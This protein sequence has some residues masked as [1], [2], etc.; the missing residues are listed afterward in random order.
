[1]PLFDPGAGR[2]LREETAEV[3]KA[4]LIARGKKG[5]EVEQERLRQFERLGE[6][7]ARLKS[8]VEQIAAKLSSQHEPL[9][10]PIPAPSLDRNSTL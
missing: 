3:R 7:R 1:M 9:L 10:F 6:I 8:L 5:Y 2:K 4:I